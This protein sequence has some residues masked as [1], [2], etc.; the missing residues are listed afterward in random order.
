MTSQTLLTSAAALF[1][2]AAVGSSLNILSQAQAQPLL[3][4]AALIAGGT[5]AYG[6][7]MMARAR[8][9]GSP[10]RAALAVSAFDVLADEVWIF[11]PRKAAFIYFN[12]AARVRSGV[13][14]A[15]RSGVPLTDLLHP[16]LHRDLHDAVVHGNPGTAPATVRLGQTTFQVTLRCFAGDDG[17]GYIMLMLHDISYQLAEEQR[18]ADFIST[19]SHELRSPLTSIK[20]SM[21]LLLSN[22]A[23]D[24]PGAARSM[25]EISHRNAERLVLIINDI[26]DLEKI[27]KGGCISM[28]NRLILRRLSMKRARLLPCLCSAL[29]W[30]STSLAESAPF[31]STRMQTASC[32]CSTIC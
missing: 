18:K 6:S 17:A 32:R 9:G 28:S 30:K 3:L 14:D 19:V 31:G 7:L 29:I 13:V 21:G 26:L 22:A 2:G 24:L 20:G 15:S 10:G 16:E 25:V 12:E 11:D 1:A 27:S 5:A 23:G 4:A 8:G